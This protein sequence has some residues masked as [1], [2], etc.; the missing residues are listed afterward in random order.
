MCRGEHHSLAGGAPYGGY[1]GGG[2]WVG[3]ETAGAPY[4]GSNFV[5]GNYMGLD[6]GLHGV[7]V[8]SVER[9]QTWQVGRARGVHRGREVWSCPVVGMLPSRSAGSATPEALQP[10]MRHPAGS[11]IFFAMAPASRLLRLPDGMAKSGGAA[12]PRPVRDQA[13]IK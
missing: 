11:P 6:V 10:A 5:I 8:A 13:Y 12:M 3:N 7:Q 2:V 9:G 1:G 4:R